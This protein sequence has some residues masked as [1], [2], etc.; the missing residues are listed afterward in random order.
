[1]IGFARAL[2]R[3]RERV[4]KDL[5]R[6]GMP[7]EKALACAVR[8]LD[9]GFFRIGSEDYAEENDTYG[10]ATM[11]KR[12]VT[13]D[14]DEVTLRLRG[15][16]RPA[17]RPDDRRPRGR[18][19]SCA[20][21]KR[22]RGGGEEL[23]AYKRRRAAGWTSSRPTS[24]STSRRPPAASSAR[25]TSA[26]GAATVLA[27]VALAVS[28]P[29][30]GTKTLAQARQGARGQGGRALPRQHAG[31]RARLVHRP[32][33]VRPLRRRP[34]DRGRAA[35]AGRGHGGRGRTS[36]GTIEEAVLDLIAG[37]P[38]V[39]SSRGGSGAGRGRLGAAAEVRRV[40]A[41]HRRP[42]GVP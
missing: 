26:P 16:G 40:G 35:R 39:G 9:R 32:A 1:M 27:A 7:R 31:G 20:T 18:R 24:T 41:G 17:P 34:D 15:Q 30:R 10:I 11:R 36:S 25:R 6:D 12:H 42:T 38:R 22:R 4:A 8:L 19:G 5:A 14:G 2:P 3:L 33:R 37:Q 23:L 13:V 21:L 29:A 28:G